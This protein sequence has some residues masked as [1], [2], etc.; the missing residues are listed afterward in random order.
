MT[1]EDYVILAREQLPDLLA[2]DPCCRCRTLFDWLAEL[3]NEVGDGEP[4][5]PWHQF[6]TAL[7]LVDRRH[8]F[9]H[10]DRIKGAVEVGD[11]LRAERN[12]P[13][14]ETIWTDLWSGWWANHPELGAQP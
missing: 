3:A 8:E 1:Y 12:P 13:L 2:C 11:R 7:A 14:W 4:F 6:L 9:I 5:G 10:R